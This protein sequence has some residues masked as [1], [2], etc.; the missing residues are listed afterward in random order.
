MGASQSKRKDAQRGKIH[1][2]FTPLL[3]R[4]IKSIEYRNLNHAARSLL[5]DIAT[6]YDGNNNGKLVACSKYLKPLGW[7]SHDTV[8]RSLKEL[9]KGGFL[10]RT[11]QGMRPPMAQPTW[12][13]LGW[14][15]LDVTDGLE[16]S[17]RA[18][19][20][21]IFTP[22]NALVPIKKIRPTIREGASQITPVNGLREISN[23]PING[24]VNA[25]IKQESNPIGGE[26]IYLPSTV[27]TC[28]GDSS[29]VIH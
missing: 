16:I 26:F 15:E 11:R 6:Q 27:E 4:V 25:I 24:M 21:S 1:G 23:D 3:H 29:K 22:I 13:A 12:Y 5:F 2:R 7:T 19:R 8:S 18:Y 10:I 9:E 14:L 17:Q 20:K 28:A